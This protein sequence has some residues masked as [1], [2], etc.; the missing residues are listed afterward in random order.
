M[1]IRTEIPS[2]I[3]QIDTLL[4]KAF[5]TDAESN[6]TTKLRENGKVIFSAV[7]CN[8][9]NQVVGHIL[10][11]TVTLDGKDHSYLGLAPL[12]VAKEYRRQGI[13]QQLLT[14]SLE[15][16]AEFGHRAVFTLGE[17]MVYHNSGFMTA[18][19]F[20]CKWPVPSE[21]FMA[22]ELTPNA[23]A[24]RSGLIEYQPEFDIF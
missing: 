23:L 16:L 4:K 19:N 21:F 12:A 2:D 1:L 14:F 11:T 15:S 24:G 5:D 18:A 7:A 8:D 13:A 6:L 20:R 3:T 22:V 10:F 17:P 9:E